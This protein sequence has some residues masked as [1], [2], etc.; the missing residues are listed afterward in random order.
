MAAR[1]DRATLRRQAALLFG[2]AA[3]LAGGT[4]S[5]IAVAAGGV[6]LLV[7]QEFTENAHV[8]YYEHSADDVWSLVRVAVVDLA[9]DRAPVLDD[10][11]RTAELTIEG[12][13]AAIRVEPRSGQRCRILV[14]ARKLGVYNASLAEF[15]QTMLGR[16]LDNR[17]PHP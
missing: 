2:C 8:A 5:C 7:S 4:S 1:S 3:A 10:A 15:T 14:G 9:D 6:G 17:A 13:R 11:A 16:A 12:G